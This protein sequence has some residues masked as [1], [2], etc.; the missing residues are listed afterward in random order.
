MVFFFQTVY[1]LIMG[2]EKCF[3][4][5][6]ELSHY[7]WKGW[8]ARKYFLRMQMSVTRLLVWWFRSREIII[9]RIDIGTTNSF[10]YVYACFYP[11]VDMYKCSCGY[12]TFT[13]LAFSW[14]MLDT[15][16]VSRNT[17]VIDTHYYENDV[18]CM[19]GRNNF[20]CLH[21]YN[22]LIIWNVNRNVHSHFYVYFGRRVAF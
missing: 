22:A 7:M 18:T 20:Q 19:W 12:Q 13:M 17:R 5:V 6:L 14:F 8:V 11:Y 4:F 2:I 3:Q 16:I 10:I 9:R 15:I 21:C 1:T